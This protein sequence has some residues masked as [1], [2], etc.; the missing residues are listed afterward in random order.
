MQ[1]E[2]G[3]RKSEHKRARLQNCAAEK[4]LRRHV[5]HTQK[6][7]HLMDMLNISASIAHIWIT[8]VDTHGNQQNQHLFYIKVRKRKTN[9]SI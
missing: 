9:A 6:R 1:G 4:F 3:N 8:P 7:A 2:I 5:F